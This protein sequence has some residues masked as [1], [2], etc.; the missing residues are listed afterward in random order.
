MSKLEIGVSADVSGVESALAKVQ[1]AAEKVNKT[2]NSG[3]IGIDVKEIE[4]DLSS[5]EE[6]ANSLG[7]ALGKA[8]EAGGKL[9]G[10]DLAEVEQTLKGA[11]DNAALLEQVLTAV[12]K[13]SGAT[14]AVKNSA[15]IAKNYKDAARSHAVMTNERLKLSREERFAQMQRDKTPGM[16]RLQGMSY[17]EYESGGWRRLDADERR[18]WKK[19][20][21]I[22]KNIG[23]ATGGKP[24]GGKLRN[25][26]MNQAQSGGGGRIAGA[27]GGMAGGMMGGGDGGLWSSIGGG[28]GSLI[29]AGAGALIGGPVGAI[30]GGII[31]GFA[32][33]ALGGMG[34]VIDQGIQRSA[35]EG[36]DLSA[37]RQSVGATK[38]D[39]ET[40][41]DSVRHFS[42]GLGVTY[43]EAAKLAQQFTQ[44]AGAVKDEKDI[45]RSTAD[46]IAFARGA[47]SDKNQS[48]QFF[49]MMRQYGLSNDDKSARRLGIQ[50]SE[51]IARGGMSAKTGEALS[52]IQSYV[53][54]QTQRQ[55][56][57]A[58]G[59]GFAAMLAG[60]TSSGVAG[61][62]GN[63][64]NAAAI[65]SRISDALSRGGN[66]GEAS[67]TASLGAYQRFYGNKFTAFDAGMIDEHGAFDDLSTAFDNKI[68]LAEAMG[69]HAKARELREFAA[70]G[71]GQTKVGLQMK[72]LKDVHGGNVDAFLEGGGN[73]LGL[74]KNQLA[75]FAELWGKTGGMKD[76]GGRLKAAG[77]D[78]SNMKPSQQMS[79]ALLAYGN[80]D[81]LDKQAALLRARQGDKALSKE[82]AIT[83]N[84]PVEN[85]EEYRNRILSLSNKYDTTGDQGRGMLDNQVK[86]ANATQLLA[87]QLIPLTEGIKGYMADLVLALAPNSKLAK[88]EKERINA[89]KSLSELDEALAKAQENAKTLSPGSAS[90]AVNNSA[91]KALRERKAGEIAR[92]QELAM[93]DE[94]DSDYR[95][96]AKSLNPENYK[97][98]EAEK[99]AVAEKKEAEKG[100]ASANPPP[101]APSGAPAFAASLTSSPEAAKSAAATVSPSVKAGAGK[102]WMPRN[103]RN[104]NPGNIIYGAFAREMGATGKDGIYAVFPDKAAG[105]EAM[106]ELLRRYGKQGRNTPLSIASKWAPKGHG[107]NDPE[108]YAAHIAR[109]LGVKGINDRLDMSDASVI[110]R[111]G[112]AKA[113]MEGSESAYASKIPLEARR[114]AQA[115][116]IK[117]AATGELTVVD[118]HRRPTGQTVPLA[119]KV[120]KPAWAG[121]WL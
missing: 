19:K 62:N 53:Q 79:L 121:Q 85:P 63:P 54:S 3:E 6:S 50:I 42:G 21:G 28:G 67:K 112:S 20:Q 92:A 108:K 60:L 43:N 72:M 119:F 109:R 61:L 102:A 36:A 99:Q 107:D 8:K 24:G 115:D 51:A 91:M 89:K 93:K 101:A 32:S 22:D 97:K 66:F 95:E 64:G 106:R 68:R 39:F 44:T 96:W 30:A 55:M 16:S 34:G 10:L 13:S 15:A 57:S 25:W 82:D 90:A 75:V 116:G 83:L 35:G 4:A 74:S 5:L 100:P 52:A 118:Q 11:A 113:A 2:L 23:G 65:M 87:T 26:L 81:V 114:N 110:D 77:L 76:L 73:H 14:A 41:R 69:D 12:G 59:A 80:R 9:E 94:A 33:K 29:G 84:K 120:D 47:G 103:E 117:V 37:L 111:I 78:E 88:E 86:M 46:A 45:A 1:A 105:S 7:K 18:A 31:G 104:N 27:L 71:K 49:G 98:L 38:I 48:V 58:D 40:L 17:D 56:S 70:K